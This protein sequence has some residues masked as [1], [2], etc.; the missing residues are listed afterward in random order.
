MANSTVLEALDGLKAP[1]YI[2]FEPITVF[3]IAF[4]LLRIFSIMTSVLT[5]IILNKMKTKIPVYKYIRFMTYSDL[6]YISLLF[7]FRMLELLCTKNPA[8]GCPSI[9]YSYLLAYVW[10]SDFFTSCLAFFNILVEIFIQLHRTLVVLNRLS[11]AKFVSKCKWASFY[12]SLVA[13]LV[14]TPV[15]FMKRIELKSLNG[16]NSNTTE[17]KEYHLVRTEFGKSNVSHNLLNSINFIRIFLIICILL[18]LNLVIL[19][20]FRIFLKKRKLD[21]NAISICYN[22]TRI[23]QKPKS[24]ASATNKNMTHMLIVIAFAYITG[25]LP[26]SIYFVLKVRHGIV[27]QNL[28]LFSRLTFIVFIIFKFFVYRYFS[29]LFRAQL[30][31]YLNKLA[32][33]S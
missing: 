11:A 7:I 33:C 1:A 19:I 16:N 4:E 9:Q 3:L 27:L 13:L 30:R 31:L 6:I 18:V 15:L 5:I 26:Y 28:F 22:S 23:G 21:L 12:F 17:L 20:R 29:K 10:I 25:Y 14:Y 24:I 32:D 8:H 2:F